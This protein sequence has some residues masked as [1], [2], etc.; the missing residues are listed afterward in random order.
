VLTLVNQSRQASGQA[1]WTRASQL[2][3]AAMG[4][5]LDMAQHGFVGTQG[6]DGSA[7]ADRLTRA[8]YAWRA[9]SELVGQSFTSSPATLV[10]SMMRDPSQKQYLLSSVYTECGIAIVAQPGS[11]NVFY[12]CVDL[13]AR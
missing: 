1:P 13:G 10:A 7:F 2:D 9:A 5:A 8:G 11:T 3:Q 12:W 6:S 4:H